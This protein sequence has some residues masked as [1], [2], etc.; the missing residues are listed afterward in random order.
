MKVRVTQ[1]LVFIVD[2]EVPDEVA[3][4]RQRLRDH[5]CNNTAPLTSVDQLEWVG[6]D[7]SNAETGEE[8]TDI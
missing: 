8:L 6:T 2:I 7:F 5:W 4:D 3:T 1:T